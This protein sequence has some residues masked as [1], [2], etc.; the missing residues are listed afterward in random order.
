[1]ARALQSEYKKEYK[2]MGMQQHLKQNNSRDESNNR[3]V[4][5]SKPVNSEKNRSNGAQH[6]HFNPPPIQ[7][8][9]MDDDWEFS[10]YNPFP[11]APVE[12]WGFQEQQVEKPQQS[13]TQHQTRSSDRN[14]KDRIPTVVDIT[15]P[16]TSSDR[17]IR[18]SG[19][20]EEVE[21]TLEDLTNITRQARAISRSK[22]RDEA[23]NEK[24]HA[25]NSTSIK[26]AKSSSDTRRQQ[27]NSSERRSTESHP[28]NTRRQLQGD[29]LSRRNL[30][31]AT[32][33]T[34]VSGRQLNYSTRNINTST[35]NLNASTRNLNASTRNLNAS[36]RNLNSSTRH[37][38]LNDPDFARRAPRR[39]DSRDATPRFIA[40]QQNNP[41]SLQVEETTVDDEALA[42]ELQE[43]EVREARAEPVS[44]P[45]PSTRPTMTRS[46]SNDFI[47]GNPIPRNPVSH[48]GPAGIVITSN[49]RMLSDEELARRIAQE[50][51]DA[52]FARSISAND[53]IRGT[54]VPQKKTCMASL[55]QSVGRLVSCLVSLCL[56]AVAVGL[57]IWYFG[58]EDN[59]PDF[60][61]TP[62]MFTKED[63][64]HE[65]NPGD[66]NRWR[67]DGKGLKL[68]LVNALD[69]Q[70]NTYFYT[71]LDDWDKGDPDSLNLQ[72]TV[73][74]P[75]SECTSETG[76]I[77][78]CNGDYGATSW[79]GI[80]KVM[81]ENG[82][83]Y[84]SAAKMNEFY[85]KGEDAFQR[86]YTMCHEIGHGFGLPH[87][88][89]NFYNADLGNC[90]DYTNN[91]KNNMQPSALNF[92]FLAEL[93]GT[94]DGKY[95]PT[96]NSTVIES[97]SPVSPDNSSEKPKH[98][99]DDEY[100][101]HPLPK[102]K[103][104]D[105]KLSDEESLKEEKRNRMIKISE[106]MDKLFDSG[107][108]RRELVGS[109]RLRST[110]NKDFDEISF[111]LE[112]G[113]AVRYHLLLAEDSL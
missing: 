84:A 72:M 43:A 42:R 56:L 30:Y 49:G 61:P 80:N 85:F 52:V 25:S 107:R 83:I 110:S 108:Y 33:N 79:R 20:P 39:T 50:E 37:L 2:R 21:I 69:E 36:S 91:P 58:G 70:W 5:R 38:N 46:H 9:F 13:Q 3:P 62:D 101:D 92:K 22:S 68:T 48:G 105:R 113:Y 106:D 81:L 102:P 4:S 29:N 111:D 17:R 60:I 66:S 10:N 55:F 41:T 112:D 86:Q 71:A 90:M 59:L 88:D 98:D 53:Q 12:S 67:N 47:M 6:T 75:S 45:A 35:R 54:P 109:R 44:R 57:L 32:R 65:K 76:V 95:T 40:A 104:N 14:R 82:Y 94:F 8:D 26:S 77:K 34:N 78:V 16:S 74:N 100:E 93:Y 96:N 28:D 99:D 89:E 11:S 103:H 87:T 24:M 19:V 63:P 15:Q 23:L 51:Q 73:G 7:P 97:S 18:D 31:A 1:M 27:S 64:F